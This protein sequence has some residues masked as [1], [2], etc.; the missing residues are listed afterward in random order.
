MNLY[1]SRDKFNLKNELPKI[2]NKRYININ[3][4]ECSINWLVW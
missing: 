2:K 4:K 3:T 1:I